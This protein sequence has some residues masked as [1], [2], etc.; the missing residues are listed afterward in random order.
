MIRAATPN[1]AQ[2][3]LQLIRELADY[4]GAAHLVVCDEAGLR[5]HLFGPRPFAEVLLAEEVGEITGYALFYHTFST[6]LGKPGLYLE[7]LFIKPSYRRRGH[8]KALLCAVAG[9]AVDRGCPKLE[10]E[11]LDWNEPAI[12]FYRSLG[13]IPIEDRT[14]FALRGDALTNLATAQN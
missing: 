14:V 9:L 4:E 8:G 5:Q 2:V 12:R 10:W 6:F 1:D 11:V 13:A 7:D 3:I